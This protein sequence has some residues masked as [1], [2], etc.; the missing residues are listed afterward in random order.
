MVVVISTTNRT[1]VLRHVRQGS[2]WRDTW[3]VIKLHLVWLLLYA[4]LRVHRLCPYIHE[5]PMRRCTSPKSK[6]ACPS[7]VSIIV[8]HIQ[9]M[10]SAYLRRL[11][12]LPLFIIFTRLPH[13]ALGGLQNITVDDLDPRIIYIPA[14]SWS[15]GQTCPPSSCVAQPDHQRAFKNSWND[16]SFIPNMSGEPQNATFSFNG[17]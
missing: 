4:H 11:S 5:P 17:M 7:G 16:T 2:E 9:Q 3:L 10:T 8:L 1:S 15:V 14:R 12:Y 6:L 13:Y